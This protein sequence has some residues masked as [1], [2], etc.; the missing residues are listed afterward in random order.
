MPEAAI[1]VTGGAGMIGSRLVRRLVAL[2][3]RVLVVDNLWRGRLDYLTDDSG[4][5]VI[6]LDRDFHR[7]DLA[8]PGMLDDLLPAVGTVIHLADIVAG[9]GFVFANQGFLFRQNIL[10][11]SNTVASVAR[12]K[13]LTGY[14]YVGT[15]CSFP[16]SKQTGVDAPPLVEADLYP[17]QPESAYGWSKLMGIYEAELMASEMGIPVALPVLHNV[18][19]SPCDIDPK[20]SQV[21]PALVRRAVAWPAE[22]FV[23]WGSGAQGRAFVHVEDVVDGIVAAMEGGLGAGPIQIGPDRC[24]SIREVAETV[25]AISGKPIPIVYD[26]S[27]PEGD[28]GRCADYGKAREVLGWQPRIGLRAGLED[29]YHWVEGTLHSGSD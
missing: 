12:A 28:R 27:R 2:G 3:R 7:R 25:V 24:T 22:P 21:I 23:V 20:R 6:N 13:H 9:I 18:Y 16:A 19:G 15:A 26:T 29:V 11:N 17:A 1:L 14:V 4:R 5:P 10:I 8:V